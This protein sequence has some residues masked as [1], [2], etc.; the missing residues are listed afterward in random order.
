MIVVFPV[1]YVGYKVVHKTK[2]HEPDEVDLQKDLDVI[3][4]YE[5][6]YTPRPVTYAAPA[7]PAPIPDKTKRLTML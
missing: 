3:E 1:L 4:E 6:N 2:M 5:R 7:A